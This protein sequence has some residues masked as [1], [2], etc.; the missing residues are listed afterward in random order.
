[1]AAG[2]KRGSAGDRVLE[3]RHVIGLFFLMLL[4]SGVF[5]TLGYVMGRNQF[6]GQVRAETSTRPSDMVINS[7]PESNSK[8]TK[9]VPQ[10]EPATDPVTPP[11]SDW[12]FYHSGENKA[13]DEHLK[14]APASSAPAKT[15]AAA[16][17]R[18]LTVA[19]KPLNT[20]VQKSSPGAPQIPRGA[21][22]VQVAA[23][24]KQ[25]DAMSVAS[26]L[27]KRKFPAY[28]VP[29]QGDKYF[30]VQVGPYPSQKA[31]DAARKSIESAGFKAIVKRG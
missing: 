2:G 15:N 17:S 20:Q 14:P 24:T 9:S 28:V 7:K 4:F 19:A 25:A 12:E 26:N 18:N 23:L 11:S 5:F 6:E 10:V 1:M 29:P 21:F 13:V 3:G 31:A 27:Q 8:Q 30:R 16:P 22:T